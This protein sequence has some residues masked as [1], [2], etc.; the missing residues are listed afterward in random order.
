[1]RLSSWVS[2]FL[3][4]LSLSSIMVECCGT[5]KLLKK[6]AFCLHQSKNHPE[7][8]SSLYGISLASDED[9]VLLSLTG[10]NHFEIVLFAWAVDVELPRQILRLPDVKV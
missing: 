7:K 1:M 5:V 10:V 9:E 6:R 8:T 2:C 3:G 4:L